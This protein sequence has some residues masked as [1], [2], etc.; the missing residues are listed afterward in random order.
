[1]RRRIFSASVATKDSGAGQANALFGCV[2][3]RGLRFGAENE[4]YWI[5][6][7][8]RMGMGSSMSAMQG[9]WPGASSGPEVSSIP[10]PLLPPMGSP[11][12]TTTP[13]IHYSIPYEIL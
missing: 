13:I 10:F 5:R 7:G 1:M 2:G 11:Q 8:E 4:V 6:L 12:H 9:T 3:A